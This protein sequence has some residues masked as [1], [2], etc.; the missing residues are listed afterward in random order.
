MKRILIFSIITVTSITR[1]APA[2]E[3]LEPDFTVETYATY[4]EPGMRRSTAMAFDNDSNLYVSQRYEGDIYVITP[5]RQVSKLVGGFG[6]LGSG[7]AWAGGTGYGG[8]LYAIEYKGTGGSRGGIIKVDVAN[9]TAS[10]FARVQD[11][12]PLAIDRTGNYGGYMYIGVSSWDRIYRVDAGGGITTFSLFPGT[13]DGGGPG[14]IAFDPGISY[15]GLMY[16]ATNYQSNHPEVSGLFTIDPSGNA[17]RFSNDLVAGSYLAFDEIGDF[18]RELFVV[19]KEEFDHDKDIWRVSAEG[20]ATKF[21]E[22]TLL[23]PYGLVFGQDGAM[24]VAE[25]DDANDTVIITRIRKIYVDDDGPGDPAPGIPGE[26]VGDPCFSDPLENGCRWHPFDSFQ[27][28]IDSINNSSRATIIVLDGTYTGIGNY[29]IDPNGLKVTI[30]SENGPSNC[31][32]NCQSN[33]RAFIFQNGENANTII[34]GFIIKNGYSTKNG[35]AIFCDGSGPVIKNCII[36]NNYAKWSGAAIW[37]QYGSN[38]LIRGCTITN[39]DCKVA[40][41]ITSY[42]SRPTI[43][44]CLI[45]DNAGYW[46]GAM[47]STKP[48]SNPSIINCTIADNL[49]INGPGGLECF[50]AGNLTVINSILWNNTGEQIFEEA[51]TASV[52]YS[53]IQILDSNGLIADANW[54]GQDNINA[55]PLFAAPEWGDYHLKSGAGRWFIFLDT[56]G[57]F[58]NDGIIDFLDLKIFTQYWLQSSLADLNNDNVVDFAD[59]A[60]LAAAWLGNDVDADINNDGIVDRLD[61]EI[62]T[63]YWLQPSLT[64]GKIVDLNDD[65]VVDFADYAILADNWMKKAAV[66]TYTDTETSPCIDTGDPGYDY[67]LEPEPNGD[68]INMGAYG[69]TPQASKSP[70]C[71]ICN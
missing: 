13:V 33:G 6:T 59:Y 2:V 60:I 55:D 3:V 61:L 70:E 18:G 22:A 38:A 44:N 69:N 57:D 40:G 47:T 50:Q 51:G 17:S 11:P 29:D 35:G 14:G 64:T 37:L 34:D 16:V 7:A 27:K 8:Y 63:R 71:A 52:T 43:E 12:G 21:A 28:A 20:I 36:R 26:F 23:Q 58:N 24:Y 45:T 4:S 25:Y 54:P 42:S 5:D 39:N 15:G 62:F 41:A 31:L 10:D 49:A 65:E 30:K 32:I 66:W 19:A 67:T 68:R 48:E 53:D 56:N 9:K 46:S 1:P